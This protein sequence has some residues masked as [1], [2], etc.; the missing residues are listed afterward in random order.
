VNN[1]LRL[2]YKQSKRHSALYLV[3][4][5]LMFSS[6][7]SAIDLQCSIA[8]NAQIKP[9]VRALMIDAADKGY[10][11]YTDNSTSLVTF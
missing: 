11:Y 6:P 4:F 9:A 1:Y 2:L 3:S 7:A 10:L 8:E 5:W